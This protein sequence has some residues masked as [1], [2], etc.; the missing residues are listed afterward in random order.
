M[1]F[2][3][4]DEEDGFLADINVTPLVDVMLVLLI[5]FMITAPML[6]KGIEVV[7]P[8]S[9]SGVVTSTVEEPVIV[10]IDQKGRIFV[11]EQ[12][13]HITRLVEVLMP[14]LNYR[15][16]KVVL[17]KGDKRVNYGLI[18]EVLDLLKDNG[19]SNVGLITKEKRSDKKRR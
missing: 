10:S 11:E 13:V 17:I 16:E 15:K 1:G 18:V 6:Q 19:I 7:L 8:E 3:G 9:K 12:P 5:V 14:R 4:F 2:T